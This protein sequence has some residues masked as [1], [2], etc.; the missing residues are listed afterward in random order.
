MFIVFESVCKFNIAD[1]QGDNLL[2]NG[3]NL[4]VSGTNLCDY[5]NIFIVF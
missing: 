2:V 5:S 3:L 4:L 1:L